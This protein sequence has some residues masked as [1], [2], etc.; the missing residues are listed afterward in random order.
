[1]GDEAD[2]EASVPVST[3]SVNFPCLKASPQKIND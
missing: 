1:M 2:A 3:K